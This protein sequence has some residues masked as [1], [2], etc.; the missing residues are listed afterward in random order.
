MKLLNCCL[1]LATAVALSNSS[2]AQIQAFKATASDG[3]AYHTLGYS[4]AIENDLLVVGALSATGNTMYSGAVYAFGL[5]Q[6]QEVHKL[7]ASDGLAGDGFACCVALD[8]TWIVVGAPRVDGANIDSGAVYVY[9]RTTGTEV[10]KL[11]G[12]GATSGEQFGW[13]V[14]V[15]NGIAV[16][17]AVFDNEKASDAG[18]AYVWDITNK[19]QLYK[20]MASDASVDAEFGWSVAIDGDT[21]IVGARND[22]S[23]G[24]IGSA[25][26]FDAQTGLEVAKLMP[27]DG[28]AVDRFGA[29]VA[30]TGNR[31]AVGAPEKNLPG[32]N[33]AGGTYLFDASTGVELA[34]LSSPAPFASAQF[35][36][37]VAMKGKR[38]VVGAPNDKGAV[39]QTGS[40]Y[41]FDS[42]TGALIHQLLPLGTTGTEECGWSIATDGEFYV[43][44][45]K[46]A[47]GVGVDSGAVY[48][49]DDL[50]TQVGGT[51]CWSWP[52]STG[53]VAEI[54]SFGSTGVA[55]NA[56]SL[57]AYYLPPN[58]F[59]YMVNSQTQGFLAFPGG[60]QGNLCLGGQIGRHSKQ[61]QTTGLGFV[62]MTIDLT[63]LPTP[64]GPYSAIAG[65][66]WN[67]QFWYRDFNQNPTSNFTYGAS[68]TFQ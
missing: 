20:L 65:E 59:G 62:D 7:F 30:V 57:R 39:F 31:V 64:G 19:Q 66:T 45:A 12:P 40:A 50:T 63:Q 44:G 52:N 15:S 5:P 61:V 13:S 55:D 53:L 25:Y 67:W 46:R 37:S 41:V 8:S 58:Q 14:A 38:L 21:I 4:V 29:A 35:G 27:S 60:S 43:A 51:Y 34:I 6:G 36:R 28:A 22:L 47:N 49:F 2:S 1:L 26:V 54:H 10:A 68:V 3:G 24:Q 16:I 56:L 9:D 18:A 32:L 42:S 33:D 23:N 48:A 17:G 11:N